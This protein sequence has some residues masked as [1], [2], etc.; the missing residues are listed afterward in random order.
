[1]NANP[2]DG[3]AAARK[4]HADARIAGVFLVVAIV[5]AVLVGGP[6]SRVFFAVTVPAGLG[7]AALLYGNVRRRR[8]TVHSIRVDGR[9]AALVFVVA[10]SAAIVVGGAWFRLFFALGVP[11]GLA[12]AL[13]L[14]RNRRG[15]AL[16]K[17]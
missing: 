6:W 14:H 8:I 5:A 10:C 12:I 1:M 17:L 7:I 11:I 15:F 2:R 13:I 4:V 9:V 16:I 3:K